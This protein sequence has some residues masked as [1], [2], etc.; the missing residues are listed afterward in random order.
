MLRPLWWYRYAIV[1]RP[2]RQSR[3]KLALEEVMSSQSDS[4]L[5]AAQQQLTHTSDAS[6]HIV[7][8]T[9]AQQIEL[10][11]RSQ[12]QYAKQHPQHA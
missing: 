4:A 1:T 7:V 9:I 2:V 5:F 10:R 8:D 12:A 11:A 3:L 6:A